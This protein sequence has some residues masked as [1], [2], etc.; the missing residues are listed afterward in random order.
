MQV[1]KTKLEND[2][3]DEMMWKIKHTFNIY[4]IKFIIW[5]NGL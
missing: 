3:A 5:R 2:K 1:Y 4:R